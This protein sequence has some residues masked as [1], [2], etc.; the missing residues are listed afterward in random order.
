MKGTHR[1]SCIEGLADISSN[2]AS[3]CSFSLVTDVSAAAARACAA[4]SC[5]RPGRSKGASA[6]FNA[7]AEGADAEEA[8][9]AAVPPVGCVFKTTNRVRISMDFQMHI[10]TTAH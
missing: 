7:D 10:T 9:T 8:A 5:L 4:L 1:H 2:R 6:P 3:F